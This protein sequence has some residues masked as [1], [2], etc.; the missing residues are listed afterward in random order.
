MDW[1]NKKLIINRGKGEEPRIINIDRM[2]L[3]VIKIYLRYRKPKKKDEKA[4]FLNKHGIRIGKTALR[5]LI[6]YN[7][8]EAGITKRIT[9]HSFRRFTATLMHDNGKTLRNIMAQTGHKSVDT[10]VKHYIQSSSRHYKNA[11][12][13]AMSSLERKSESNYKPEEE[14][15]KGYQ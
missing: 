8:V 11:Y 1:R 10:L 14:K 6:I 3:D 5:N 7:L 4:L 2:A 15:D 13:D 9:P 12:E